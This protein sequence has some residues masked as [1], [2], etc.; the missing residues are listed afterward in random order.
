VQE[1]QNGKPFHEKP[2][3]YYVIIELGGDASKADESKMKV[4]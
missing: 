2:Y 1:L 4:K 3:L